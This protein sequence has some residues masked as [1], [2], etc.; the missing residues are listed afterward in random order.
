MSPLGEAGQ[1][2]A[3]LCAEKLVWKCSELLLAFSLAR[4]YAMT[5]ELQQLYVCRR[6]DSLVPVIV[7]C[8]W[9]RRFFSNSSSSTSCGSVTR[10]NVTSS[11]A[12]FVARSAFLF[13][14]QHLQQVTRLSS[15]VRF[16]EAFA[17]RT[18]KRRNIVLPVLFEFYL[19]I[20]CIGARGSIVGCG[21]LVQA[22]RLRIRVPMRLLNFSIDHILPAAL[23]P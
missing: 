15:S 3:W 21:T 9:G 23:W 2:V 16:K 20:L 8:Y 5:C 7:R 10:S 19:D 22:G 13:P 4:Q 1:S 12:I 18:A 11:M 17:I 14:D 6:R